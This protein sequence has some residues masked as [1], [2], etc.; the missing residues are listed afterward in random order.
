MTGMLVRKVWP[1]DT[2][3]DEPG[4]VAKNSMVNEVKKMPRPPKVQPVW[5]LPLASVV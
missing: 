3:L 4:P 5:M 1:S 2:P